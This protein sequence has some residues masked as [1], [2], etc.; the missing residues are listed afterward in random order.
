MDQK[1]AK[2]MKPRKWLTKG[3]EKLG[4][5]R[6]EFGQIAGCCEGLIGWLEEGTTITHPHIAARI[7]HAIGGN[8]RQYNSLIHQSHW[9]K[10]LPKA[11]P[12]KQQCMLV[13]KKC[14]ECGEEFET[15]RSAQRFC[16]IN[17]STKN[18]HK[19]RKEREQLNDEKKCRK[20]MHI[21]EG[22]H[23]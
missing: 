4:L 19:V 2:S 10:E 8:V 20:I 17:C 15:Y 21:M 9:K 23:G 18:A 6:F 14:E 3:R 5:S 1:Q 11:R 13:K 12:V 7:V 22:K 16:S